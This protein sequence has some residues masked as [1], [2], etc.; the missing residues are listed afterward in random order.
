MLMI[1]NL[2]VLVI[3]NDAYRALFVPEMEYKFVQ[4]GTKVVSW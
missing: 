4:F 2:R 1:E 3:A